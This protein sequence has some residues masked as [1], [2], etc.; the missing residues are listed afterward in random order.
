M[1]EIIIEIAH[2]GAITIET[3]GFSGPV[4]VEDSQFVKDL[5]GPETVR[6]LLPVYYGG[7][8]KVRKYLQLC[9]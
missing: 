7:T 5:L 3:R 2:D 8:K 4:C 1:K 6:T 9:G